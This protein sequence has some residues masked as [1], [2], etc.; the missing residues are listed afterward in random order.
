[1]IKNT[2]PSESK[3]CVLNVI[4]DYLVEVTQNVDSE[5]SSMVFN[6]PVQLKHKGSFENILMPG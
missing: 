1:M 3:I 2:L 5:Y 6:L 4:I